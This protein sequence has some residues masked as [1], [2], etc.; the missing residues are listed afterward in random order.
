MSNKQIEQLLEGIE[1]LTPEFKEKATVI[2]DAAVQE[3]ADAHIAEQ[4]VAL[5]E[6]SDQ[7]VEQAIAEATE[8]FKATLDVFLDEAV[9]EWVTE[10]AVPLDG[11]LKGQIAESFING[12]AAIYESHN[13]KFDDQTAEKVAD[14]E[15]RLTEATEQLAAAQSTLNEAAVAAAEVEKTSV[16]EAAVKDLADTQKD[17]VKRLIESIE[18]KDP[19]DYAKKLS[20]IVEA[21]TGVDGAK[22]DG[23]EGKEGEK[24]GDK[25]AK[26]NEAPGKEEKIVEQHV[27]EPKMVEPVISA[28]LA[29][30]RKGR[31]Q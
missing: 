29:F 14:L 6:A 16:F 17:R 10:N 7:R 9:T 21:V 5:S 15:K 30:M 28:T 11:Q 25:G 12:L 23:E 19:A 18:V 3:A 31:K 24:D 26:P 4:T 22:K 8:K 27:E 1:G 20:F 13:V 2:F